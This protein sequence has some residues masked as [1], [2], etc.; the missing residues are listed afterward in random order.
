MFRA[1][2]IGKAIAPSKHPSM[3]GARLLVMQ[4]LNQRGGP[5][6]DPVVVV[7]RLG[8]SAGG[9]AIITNDGRAARDMMGTKQ[10]PVRYTTIGL[11]DDREEARS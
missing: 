5:D 10:T 9:V 3:E 6:G 8:A 4:I 1:R 2:V 7:D 11:E